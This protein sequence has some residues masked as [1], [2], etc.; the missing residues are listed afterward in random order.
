MF[1][2]A[3]I[4]ASRKLFSEK[5]AARLEDGII[6]QFLFLTTVSFY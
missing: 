4:S 6:M 1:K 5:Q 3:V 2:E